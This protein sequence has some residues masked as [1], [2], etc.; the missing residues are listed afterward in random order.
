MARRA[1]I[2]IAGLALGLIAVAGVVFARSAYVAPVIMY[3]SIDDK[4]RDTKLSVNP[5]SFER[6][7]AFLRGHRY[8]VVGLGA[9]AEHLEKGT[10]L[11]PKTVAVTFDDGFYNNYRDAYPSLKKY[12][13]PATI[14]VI[15]D[16]I[17]TPGYLGWD[18]LKEMSSSGLVTIGSHTRSHRWLPAMG[19]EALRHE[20]RSSKEILEQGL[21]RSVDYLCYPI[22]AHDDRVMREARMAGYTCAVA[23]NPGPGRP[24]DP[25][26]IKR[27][28]I[29]RTSDNLFVFWIETSGYYT[30]IKERRD[31]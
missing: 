20:L 5:R 23:T 13:I 2:A 3:H 29:S 11:P 1:R 26:A 19:T 24:N 21:G 28:R 25:F 30:W 18:E 10:P 8:N 22:G 12:R 15:V 27:I 7:M 16:K 4:D 14:F 31:R 6:Q 9:I 17:G